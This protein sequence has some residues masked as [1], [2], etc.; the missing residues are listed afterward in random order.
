MSNAT[1]SL[2]SR[3]YCQAVIYR[4]KDASNPV[5][6]VGYIGVLAWHDN[7]DGNAPTKIPGTD[8]TLPSMG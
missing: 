4:G 7:A 1:P 6:T 3:V 2:D 5:G 8:F